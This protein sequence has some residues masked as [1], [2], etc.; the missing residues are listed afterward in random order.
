MTS[1]DEFVL[2]LLIDKGIVD[3]AAIEAARVKVAEQDS[4]G[5]PDTDTL[6]LLI[7][8]HTVTQLQIAAV[9]AAE[10][11]MEVVD[12]ADVRVSNQALELLPYDLASRY[13]VFPLEADDNEVELAV[14]DPLDMDAIDSISHVRIMTGRRLIKWTVCSLG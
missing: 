4:E 10:F 12:L 8:E 2:Q 14:C 7:A 6:E 11:N 5:N 13:K 3:S 1:A 9:L